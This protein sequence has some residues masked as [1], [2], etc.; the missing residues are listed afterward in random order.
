MTTIDKF[1]SDPT[2][3]LSFDQVEFDPLVVSNLLQECS[4]L[5]I[6]ISTLTS[7]VGVLL[8]LRTSIALGDG[9]TALLVVG[10]VTS[11]DWSVDRSSERGRSVPERGGLLHQRHLFTAVGS[12]PDVNSGGFRLDLPLHPK[13]RLKIGGEWAFFVEGD[14]DAIGQ[15]QPNLGDASESEIESGFQEFASIMKPIYATASVTFGSRA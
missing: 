3:H 15:S 7:R 14:V 13:S 6:K 8:D 2:S 11:V 10:G 1:M 5:D 12:V 9:N 4:I